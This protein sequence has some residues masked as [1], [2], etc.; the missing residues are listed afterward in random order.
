MAF[1]APAS[2]ALLQAQGYAWATGAEQAVPGMAA[3]FSFMLI[4]IVGTQF[5]REHGWGT[6]D[7]LRTAAGAPEIMIGKMVPALLVLL[8]QLAVVFTGGGLLFSLRVTGSLAGLMLVIAAFAACV[9]ALTMAVIAFCAT[10]DQLMVMSNLLA[11][12]L[13]GLGGAFTPVS[14]LPRWAQAVAKISPAYWAIEGMHGI[15]L[16]AKGFGF[17]LRT[18]GILALFTAGFALIAAVRFNIR[19]AKV[20]DT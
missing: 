1:L 7:R 3:M 16:D 19:E 6:W 15:I 12:I 9:M 10:L 17:A 4:S 14:A 5:Y 8:C 11:M 13:S 20:S 18:A 2:R